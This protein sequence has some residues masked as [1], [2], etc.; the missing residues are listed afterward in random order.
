MLGQCYRITFTWNSTH[1]FWATGSRQCL[2]ILLVISSQADYLWPH[3]WCHLISICE[4]K[5]TQPL[6]P[7]QGTS[8]NSIVTKAVAAF[9]QNSTYIF[10]P[11]SRVSFL[12]IAAN[13]TNGSSAS[14]LKPRLLFFQC[15]SLSTL[16]HVRRD[17]TKATFLIA[18]P[19]VSRLGG[20]RDILLS[21]RHTWDTGVFHMLHLCLRC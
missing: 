12:L 3:W 6:P 10:T 15:T 11:P 8:S 1:S 18:S 4:T 2:V 17:V 19:L 21:Q 9:G 16:V 20:A 13:K 5:V 14:L 7:L